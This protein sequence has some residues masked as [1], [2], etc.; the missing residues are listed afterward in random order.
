MQVA[1]LRVVCIRL[2]LQLGLGVLKH[3]VLRG[4][5]SRLGGNACGPR[6]CTV[7]QVVVSELVVG[8]H[9][10]KKRAH[11]HPPH[12]QEGLPF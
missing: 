9:A 2:N 10:R 4:I 12:L 1:A 5:A 3:P 7:V 11:Q 8:G 6:R